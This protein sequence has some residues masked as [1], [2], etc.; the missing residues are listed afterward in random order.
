MRSKNVQG[1]F[2]NKTTASRGHKLECAYLQDTGQGARRL[3][4]LIVCVLARYNIDIAAHSETRLPDEGSIVK[5][6]TE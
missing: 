4:A 3:S 2:F 5:I 6:W 1:K